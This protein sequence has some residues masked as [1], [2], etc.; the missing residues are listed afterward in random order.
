MDTRGARCEHPYRLKEGNPLD[1][2]IAILGAGAI[3]SSIG[4]D[5]TKAGLDVV[6]ID[7]WPAHVD[8]MKTDGL[9]VTMADEDLH[10]PVRAYH[11]CEVC[12]LNTQFD[13][14]MLVAK[15]YDSL[16]MAQF[17]MP[18]LKSDGLLLSVQNSLNDEWLSPL[19]G[20]T[21]DVGC[22]VELSAE[23]FTPGHV[24][25]NT[26]RTGTWF[27]LGELHGRITPRLRELET[28]MGNVGKVNLTSNIWGAKWT[29][30]VTNTMDLAPFAMMGMGPAEAS[31]IPGMFDVCIRLGRESLAVGTRL[32]YVIEPIF[33]MSAEEFIGSTDETL[34]RILRTIVSHVKKSKRNCVLHDHLKNR[35]SEVGY[36]NGL[37]AQKG[38]EV[39]IP[40]P[41]NEAITEVTRRI[42]RGELQPVAANLALVQ[43]LLRKSAG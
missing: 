27:G 19:I 26:A 24:V 3:G 41:A 25:R 34:E 21:R 37:V 36:L 31:E 7:Q 33:G 6:L 35:Y 43:E 22:V 13:I 23:L 8:A 4:A 5:L 29:K 20:H 15:S 42:Q 38:H 40:T 39:G 28:I 30:L 32:G 17:I 9:R 14:V 16:W 2:R 12:S 1:K 18:Y 11:L 10:L